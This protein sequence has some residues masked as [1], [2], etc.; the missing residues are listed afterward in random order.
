MSAIVNQFLSRWA[1]RFFAPST[2]K[3]APPLHHPQRWN[4]FRGPALVSAVIKLEIKF[5]KPSTG[6]SDQSEV[7]ASEMGF[8][9]E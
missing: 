6:G 3:L 4:D 9:V 7:G 5:R 8:Q 1:G 2:L